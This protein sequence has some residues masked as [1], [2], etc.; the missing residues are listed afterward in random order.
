MKPID[1]E[2]LLFPFLETQKLFTPYHRTEESSSEMMITSNDEQE[3]LDSNSRAQ[4][5]RKDLAA[6]KRA[7]IIA[8]MTALQKNFIEQNSQLCSDIR[9]PTNQTEI[10]PSTT[11]EPMCIEPRIQSCLGIHENEPIPNGKPTLTCIF[12]QESSEVKLNGEALVLSAY[13]Q[14]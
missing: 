13:V 4:K 1:R 10:L 5:K 3:K 12:C 11:D 2:N 6:S 7:R 8:Q 9:D 14:R